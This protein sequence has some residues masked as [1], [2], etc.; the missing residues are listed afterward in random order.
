MSG[1][2]ELLPSSRLHHVSGLRRGSNLLW[3]LS[4][5]ER[6]LSL[7]RPTVLVLWKSH[8][9]IQPH[10]SS[11]GE[12][13]R[14]WLNGDSMNDR[15]LRRAALLQTKRIYLCLVSNFNLSCLLL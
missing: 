7:A 10:P 2:A 11:L 9:S 4:R 6:L 14:L 8:P 15:V 5:P 13:A 3:K 12:S 1:A